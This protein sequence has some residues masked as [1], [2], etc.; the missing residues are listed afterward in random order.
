M[1]FKRVTVVVIDGLG[2]GKDS[3]QECDGDKGANTLASVLKAGSANLPT[4]ERLGLSMLAEGKSK[5]RYG[6]PR[7]FVAAIESASVA[8]DTVTGH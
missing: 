7:A 3:R 6:P 5:G 1:V 4:L 2:V 8:K